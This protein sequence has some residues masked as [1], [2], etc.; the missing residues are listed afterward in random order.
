[1]T[2][3][4][5]LEAELYDVMPGRRAQTDVA[6]YRDLVER[7]GGPML[8]LACGT[9]RVSI[10]CAKAAGEVV[11]VDL[12]P[13]MLAQA[14]SRAEAEGVADVASFVEGDMCTV[15]L[16]RTFP[17]VTMGGQPL[18][19][20]PTDEALKAALETVRVHL[21]PGGRWATGVPVLHWEDL[22]AQQDRLLF[23]AEVRHPRT[24]QRVAV[25]DY[26]SVT[27]V[28]QVA[29]RRRI[30]EILDEDGLVL[31]RRHSMQTLHYRHPAELQRLIRDA[32][33]VFEEIHGS[34]QGA[35]FGPKARQMV[36]V[37][38]AADN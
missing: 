36:W 19:F 5:A 24:G 1:M 18:F 4:F 34:Y 11:G 26:T 21:A 29:T 10:P 12:A 22:A 35:P 13:A 33:F 16:D 3:A 9:G 14:R 28:T 31:E 2:K 8:E 25:W 20:L 17:L 6:F 15:R 32:G 7:H 38:R 27:E 30:T 37:A 23:V